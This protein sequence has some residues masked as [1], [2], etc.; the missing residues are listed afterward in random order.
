[1]KGLESEGVALKKQVE[2]RIQELTRT[3]AEAV[4]DSIEKKHRR[5]EAEAEGARGEAA[6]CQP[7]R[8]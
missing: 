1:L 6:V 5:P 3:K 4:R 2:V 8:P 7:C